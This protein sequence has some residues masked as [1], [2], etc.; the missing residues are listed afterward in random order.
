MAVNQILQ[1]SHQTGTHKG[2]LT[3]T[4]L[5]PHRSR[6]NMHP[7]TLEKGI[8]QTD[9]HPNIP[10]QVTRQSGN[11]AHTDQETSC[12]TIHSK[13]AHYRQ[14][15][16]Q[17]YPYRSHGSQAFII[18]TKVTQQPGVH[19]THKGHTAVRHPLYPQ[20]SLGSQTPK[21]RPT[22]KRLEPCRDQD[23]DH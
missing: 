19:Y 9:R 6:D 4:N 23:V 5:R 15:D 18:P 2:H 12:T 11:H 20:R 7:D 14:T 1:N 10:I 8:L 17:I 3:G 16:I 22:E 13:R 21:Y